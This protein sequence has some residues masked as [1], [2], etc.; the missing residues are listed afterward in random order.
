M[1]GGGTVADAL[2]AVAVLLLMGLLTG[3]IGMLRARALVR[4]R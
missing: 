3:G 1:Q 4:A 2:P